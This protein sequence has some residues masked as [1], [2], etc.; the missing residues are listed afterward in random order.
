M[1]NL[2]EGLHL[3]KAADSSKCNIET[4]AV[5]GALKSALT[6]NLL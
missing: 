1:E 4:E 2:F 6:M 5:E 3:I